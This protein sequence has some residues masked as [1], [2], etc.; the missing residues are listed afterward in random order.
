MNI[1]YELDD[2][3][4]VVD[5]EGDELHAWKEEIVTRI[6]EEQKK[7]VWIAHDNSDV[8]MPV[9]SLNRVGKK[10]EVSVGMGLDAKSKDGRSRDSKNRNS[11]TRNSVARSSVARS[12]VARS[13]IAST[14]TKAHTMI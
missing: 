7:Y 6:R 13:S 3:V 12:S 9:E 1:E 11:L 10:D 2:R 4:I 14:A 8:V 5:V